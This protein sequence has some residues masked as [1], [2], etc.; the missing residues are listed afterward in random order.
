MSRK[1]QEMY[2]TLGM[3]PYSLV[4]NAVP[5]MA[6]I[7]KIIK[8]PVKAC[9]ASRNKMIFLLQLKRKSLNFIKG[10]TIQEKIISENVKLC[11]I[12]VIQVISCYF[13]YS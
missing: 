2:H 10:V 11:L 3:L 13:L 6:I 9:V 1:K 4:S 5:D 12:Q 8:M 7:F